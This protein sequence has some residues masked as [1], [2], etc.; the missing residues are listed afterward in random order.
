MRLL[1]RV[2]CVVLG[3]TGA[4]LGYFLP[5]DFTSGA[6]FGILAVAFGAADMVIQ[7]SLRLIDDRIKQEI[8]KVKTAFR[9]VRPLTLQRQSLLEMNLVAMICKGVTVAT[10]AMTMSGKA[11][12][13]VLS[14]GGGAF[15]LGVTLTAVI[16]VSHKHLVVKANEDA[17]KIAEETNA[18]DAVQRLG[19][20]ADEVDLPERKIIRLAVDKSVPPRKPK[21]PKA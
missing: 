14:V 18:A 6:V 16:W 17:L 9:M 2:T 1:G 8:G 3:G 19:S 4:T 13:W 15:G 5:A 12:A 7:S 10:S 11:P 21:K 20:I